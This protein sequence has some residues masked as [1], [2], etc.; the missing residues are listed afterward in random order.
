[1]LLISSKCNECCQNT[2]RPTCYYSKTNNVNMTSVQ[3][4]EKE[5]FNINE[6]LTLISP[7]RSGSANN[8]LP[9]CL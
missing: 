2:G 9:K 8:A 7:S 6:E 4:W 3:K 1:M 5:E